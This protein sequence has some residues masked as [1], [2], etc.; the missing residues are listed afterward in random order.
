M[1]EPRIVIGKVFEIVKMKPQD[2]ELK[3]LNLR[4]YEG[5]KGGGYSTNDVE[6]AFEKNG[7]IYLSPEHGE[8]G[9]VYLYPEQVKM[10]KSL[11]SG[12]QS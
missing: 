11:L 10:L 4:Y 7:A 8:G 3:R 1:T 12:R 6:V 9:G 2:D 5:T